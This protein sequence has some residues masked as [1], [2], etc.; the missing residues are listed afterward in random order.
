MAEQENEN[1]INGENIDTEENVI[2]GEDINTEENVI[3][4]D[5]NKKNK[6]NKNNKNKD[7]SDDPKYEPMSFG[8][9]LGTLFILAIPIVGWVFYLLWL[10]GVGNKNR[11]RFI[12]AKFVLSLIFLIIFAIIIIASMSTILTFFDQ[13]VNATN[14][15]SFFMMI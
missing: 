13:I 3:T 14:S 2:N 15:S 12:R 5:K 11:V 9:W 6:K 7:H 10:C 4:E 1:V 8:A